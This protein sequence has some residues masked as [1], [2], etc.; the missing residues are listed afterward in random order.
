MNT[1]VL[2]AGPSATAKTGA[3][4]TGR[5]TL[6]QGLS[7]LKDASRRFAL[8]PIAEKV[9]L[10]R[11]VQAGLG[12]VAEGW[13]R[14]GARAKGIEYGPTPLSG[15]EWLAGPMA[16]SRNVR[17]LIETL[18][19][20]QHKGRPRLGRSARTR[21][22]G[23]LEIEVLP[24]GG[25]DPIIHQG[26]HCVALMQP[27]VDEARARELQASFYKEA[28]PEGKVSLI[29]GAGNVS[30]IPVL[31]TMYRMFVEG[32]VCVLKMNPVNEWV[33]PFL[34]RALA[35]LIEKDYLRIVYGG[36]DVGEYLCQHPAVDDIHITGSDRTHDRIVWGPPGPEQDRRKREG[37]PVLRKRITSELGNVSPVAVVPGK[38]TEKELAFQARNLVAMM[39]NNAS[40]NCNAAKLLITARG[41]PQRDRFLDLFRAEMAKVPPRF[42]YY[43]GARDRYQQLVGGRRGGVEVLGAPG[44]EEAGTLPWTLIRDVDAKAA[45]EP[46]FR[47]EPF[48]SI[49][50]HTEL[51]SPDPAAFLGE[52]TGFCNDRVWG[53]LNAMLVIDPRTERDPAVAA[54]LDR[55][56]L[57]LRYGT[58]AINLWPAVCYGSISPPWGGHPSGT[59]EDIQSGVGWVHNSFML[60]GIE[61]SVLRGAITL[62]PKPI[63]YQDNRLTHLIGER[64]TRFELDP[65]PGRAAPLIWAA[66]RG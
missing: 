65:G 4:P 27:G 26:L 7:A 11:V 36:A 6:D 24:A 51:D 59:L 15:E 48:C 53:T 12:D 17:L 60:E 8:L 47:V 37:Q 56:V 20:I 14:A 22:D 40:F 64:L 39:A 10:L 19:E 58:V 41:W 57:D 25:W 35:P 34:E 18:E 31:D 3:P 50:S 38:L 2:E 13:A 55:A 16:T 46:L 62:S 23:R 1:A 29:L 30:S 44:S 66:L 5:P 42:A 45:G 54:A 63:W 52:V 61:K 32:S 33:G 28:S 21:P 43:P 49:I 9:K